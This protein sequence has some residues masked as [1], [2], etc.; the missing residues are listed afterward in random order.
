MQGQ[1]EGRE[2][3]VVDVPVQALVNLFDGAG[4]QLRAYV[5]TDLPNGAPLA[6][7]EFA[8][9]LALTTH[10]ATELRALATRAFHLAD[11]LD[12]ARTGDLVGAV[13]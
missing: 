11:E 6:I 7:L 5:R 3:D 12:A 13:S 1:E 8:G 10:Q 4:A 9:V 2:P